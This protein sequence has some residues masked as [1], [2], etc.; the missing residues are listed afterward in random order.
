MRFATT[1][2]LLALFAESVNAQVGCVTLGRDSVD[3]TGTIVRRV[4]ATQNAGVSSADDAD[5]I[6]VLKLSRRLCVRTQE[7]GKDVIRYGEVQLNVRGADANFLRA[8]RDREVMIGGP[9]HHP[10]HRWHRLPVVLYGRFLITRRPE[11]SSQPPNDELK[12]AAAVSN[13]VE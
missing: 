12:P 9:I 3:L 2:I 1:C 4:L 7:G 5:T 6:W 8:Y 10:K 13:L 11:I